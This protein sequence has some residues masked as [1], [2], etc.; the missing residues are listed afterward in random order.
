MVRE[1]LV[2]GQGYEKEDR[3]KQTILL[4]ETFFTHTKKEAELAF[5]QYF[6]PTHKII[7]IYSVEPIQHGY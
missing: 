1:F 6:E 2:T 3:Y 4:H 7:K 5:Q